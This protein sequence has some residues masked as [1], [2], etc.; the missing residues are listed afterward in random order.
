MS[1]LHS[2]HR[3]Q[4]NGVGKKASIINCPMDECQILIDHPTR[5][6]MHVADFRVSHLPIR[7]THI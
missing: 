5:P 4:E 1:L 7:Q 3:L 2:S 6:Q